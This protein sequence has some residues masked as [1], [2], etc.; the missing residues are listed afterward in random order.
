MECLPGQVQ[1]S[2][3]VSDDLCADVMGKV[4]I[5]QK[6]IT[7]TENVDDRQ[8][9]DSEFHLK[10]AT[11]SSSESSV[12]PCGGDESKKLGNDVVEIAVFKLLVM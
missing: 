10:A 2:T 3:D 7:T 1:T 5:I 8:T 12:I 4:D 6:S 11:S 9:E